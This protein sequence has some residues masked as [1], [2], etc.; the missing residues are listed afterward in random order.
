MKHQ[1][2]ENHYH[3]LGLDFGKA[4]LYMFLLPATKEA[5]YTSNNN[6][7]RQAFNLPQS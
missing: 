6:Y 3:H 1:A 2:L 5:G 7:G 4:V